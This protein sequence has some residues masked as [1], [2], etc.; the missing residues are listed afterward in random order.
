MQIGMVIFDLLAAFILTKLLA[1]AS[2][3]PR[4]IMLYL[5]NPLVI[6]E[7]AHGAHIDAWMVLLTLLAIWLTLKPAQTTRTKWAAP[8]V[9]ALA[10]LTKIIP[11]LAL[12]VLFW[13][14]SWRQLI[15]YGTLT[16][17]LLVPFG[18]QAGWGL[19]GE[20]NGRGLF[21]AL[22]IYSDQWKF[23]SGIWHWLQFY[24]AKNPDIADSVALAKN[25]VFLVMLII[26][27]I[28]WL[29]AYRKPSP[30]RDLR[31]LFIPFAAYITLT[32]T[33]HPWY[34][35]MM[36]AFLIF[37]A[38]SQ[39]ENRRRWL[40][41]TPWLYLGATLIFSYLTYENPNAHGEREWIRQL[42][43]IPTLSLIAISLL[44]LPYIKK[45]N[46]DLADLRR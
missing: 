29:L 43:W 25:L 33:V 23:N 9:F 22:R 34:T 5:W 44:A 2:L 19:S 46:A 32:P 10:T 41:L 36:M 26:M 17:A 11:V 38:P 1:L 21:G 20:L 31:L 42:E 37:L 30:K 18:Q 28:V 14:W 27:I 7:V 6:I 4:R 8:I 13:R 12:P 39:T 45:S 3:P 16:L 40:T 35:L 24:L 15:G